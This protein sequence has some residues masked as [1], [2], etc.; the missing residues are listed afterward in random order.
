[1][2]GR[3]EHDFIQDPDN[4]IQS[5]PKGSKDPHNRVLGSKYH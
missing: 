2:L 4:V 1:M 5:L 3:K